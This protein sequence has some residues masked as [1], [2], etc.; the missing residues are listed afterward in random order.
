MGKKLAKQEQLVAGI[1]DKETFVHCVTTEILNMVQI[2]CIL[3]SKTDSGI[4][5]LIEVGIR[6]GIAFGEKGG[7][8]DEGR[9]A[10]PGAESST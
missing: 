10:G 2:P 5:D 7:K 8:H 1:T 4:S 9:E 6:A 3:T